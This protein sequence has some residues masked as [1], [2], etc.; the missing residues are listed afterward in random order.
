MGNLIQTRTHCP[1]QPFEAPHQTQYQYDNLGRIQQEKTGT[2]RHTFYFDSASNLINDPT[3]KVINN[4]L[5][6]YQGVR[7]TYDSLGNL[8]EC[9]TA[10]GDYQRYT[11]DL[12]HQL[13]RADI[14]NRYTTESWVYDYDPL[15]RRIAKSKLNK[16]GE[17]QCHTQFIWAGSHLVQEI[18]KGKNGTETDRTFTYIYTHPGS[19]EP[20]AQCYKESENAQHTVNYFHCDQIGV[21]REMTDSQGKLLWKGRYDAWGQ[22]IHDSNRHAQRSTHQ[23]FRLQN[24]YFDQETGLHYNFLRYYEPAL[25]RFITQDPIGLMGGMNLYQ[26][27]NNTQGWIDPLGLQKVLYVMTNENTPII[28][29]HAGLAIIDTADPTKSI[30]YD[31]AGSYKNNIR[32]SGDF[33]ISNDFNYDDYIKYQTSTDG[34]SVHTHKFNIS[35]EEADRILQNIE[36][37]GGC[38]AGFCAK[39]TSKVISGGNGIFKDLESDLFPKSLGDKLKELKTK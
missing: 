29:D 1:Q 22:L 4:R 28:G 14:H 37:Q 23:P 11:Y 33:F 19:Y 26:F 7:Y 24:Q 27:A 30:L 21:P 12:K 8:T 5:S 3:E 13:I 17:K 31:P 15:G 38:T 35:D 32:W 18:R 10:N 25:G 36:E 34:P 2:Q 39:C 20:L 9:Q 6:H 16:Q